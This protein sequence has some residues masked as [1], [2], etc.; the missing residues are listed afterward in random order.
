MIH[1]YLDTA[2]TNNA[3]KERA[4]LTQLFQTQLN[5]EC[6]TAASD[7]EALVSEF[8][9]TLSERSA[10][11]HAKLVEELHSELNKANV[12]VAHASEEASRALT[13]LQRKIDNV[14]PLRS[15]RPTIDGT[16]LGDFLSPKPGAQKKILPRHPRVP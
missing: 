15:P 13:A 2:L 10:Q 6:A 7:R 9:N 11:D 4:E 3:I 8:N 5:K 14:G 12:A 16:K 1:Q